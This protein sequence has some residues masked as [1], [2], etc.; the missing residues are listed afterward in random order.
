MNKRTKIIAAG[1]A[2]AALAAGGA[3]FA[4]AGSSGD[5]EQPISGTELDQAS[6]AALEATGGGEVTETEVGDEESLYEV[7]VTKDDGTQVDVQLNRDFQVV[8]QSAD[9]EDSGADDGSDS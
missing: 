6:K 3:A 7:E 5:S 9:S 2:T 4:T 8:G 1:A